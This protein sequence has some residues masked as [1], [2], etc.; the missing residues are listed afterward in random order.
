MEYVK[1]KFSKTMDHKF[2]K[3]YEVKLEP[4]SSS[5]MQSIHVSSLTSLDDADL[6]DIKPK[7]PANHRDIKLEAPFQSLPLHSRGES[8]LLIDSYE[9]VQVSGVE[10]FTQ[11]LDCPNDCKLKVVSIFGN[12]GDGKSYT[13]NHVSVSFTINSS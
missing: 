1:N 8:F 10:E 3:Q 12:S 7:I 9:N 13:L 4:N 2:M 11:L 6:I 5:I